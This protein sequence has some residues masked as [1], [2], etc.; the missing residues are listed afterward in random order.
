MK[1]LFLGLLY[2]RQ[3]E[4]TLLSKTKKG[5]QGAVNTFQWNLIDGFDEI[6]K[7]QIQIFTSLPVGTYPKYY[8]QL[9]FTS[10]TWSHTKGAKDREIGYVNLPVFK[11]IIRRYA[12]YREVNQWCK[13]NPNDE[14]YIIAYS[15][16]LPYLKVLASI[17]KKHE[18]LCTCIIV[19]D[20]PNE[21]GFKM[22]DRC[23]KKIARKYIGK[24]QLKLTKEVDTFVLLTQ[25]MVNPLDIKDK[26]Y[27]IVEGISNP[28]ITQTKSQL[29][30]NNDKVILYT[31]TLN[32][33]FG[34]DKLVK[35]F[36]K[37]S[38]VN[39][40]LWICGVGDYQTEIEK[41]AKEDTRIKYFG[42]V[43]KDNILKMQ[44]EATILVNPRPN[45]G[46]YT[47]YSFP[48]KT[49]EYMASGKPVLMFKL[50]GIPDEYDEYLFYIKEN[51]IDSI[52]Q[53]ILD[54]CRKTSEELEARGKEGR[55]F[56][57]INKNGKIQARR[58]LN[59][60]KGTMRNSLT[61]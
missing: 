57:L 26:P 6:L 58:I 43:S 28:Q 2:N 47:K 35:A 38:L 52:K 22:Q 37:I 17:S 40:Q 1:I 27:V 41:A 54:I 7:E 23:L 59:M 39:Y 42:Y 18:N 8:K 10:K 48:S 60:L 46:E 4:K 5:L 44:Q 56:I 12:F 55:N 30:D 20:L 16:Y 51:T 14:L 3:D 11:E 49:I 61:N 29:A 21:F 31:G 34:L 24:I 50:D 33:E 19:P 9:I 32:H 15:L 25:E 13:E 36:Q 45:E 53:A